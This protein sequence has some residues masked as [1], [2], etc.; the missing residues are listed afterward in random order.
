[1]EQTIIYL[2]MVQRLVNLKQKTL[3]SMQFH[4]FY[5]RIQKAFL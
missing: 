2:L 3:K 4:Y 1:M 5:E